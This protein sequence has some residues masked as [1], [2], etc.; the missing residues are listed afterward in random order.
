MGHEKSGAVTVSYDPSVIHKTHISKQDAEKKKK[1][2]LDNQQ[3][4]QIGSSLNNMALAGSIDKDERIIKFIAAFDKGLIVTVES[5]AKY[6]NL[7]QQTIRK[8]AKEANIS[9]ID[10][11]RN[12]IL[13]GRQPKI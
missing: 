8:Y 7:S 5:G 6:M 1:E 13:P 9:L 12:K 10:T 2:Y 4:K 3:N 11:Q